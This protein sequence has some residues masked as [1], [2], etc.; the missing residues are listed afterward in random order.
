MDPGEQTTG[1]RDE[2]YN[3]VSVLYHALHGADNCD[4]YATDAEVS[5]RADLSDF[6]R[7]AQERQRGLADR[8]KGLL[9]IG[10]GT[11]TAGAG[12]TSTGA[13]PTG[14]APAGGD[15][16]GGA[17][18]AGRTS[19]A[20]G[21]PKGG[22][23]VGSDVPPTTDVLPE[24]D[25]PPRGADDLRA[26]TVPPPA[27]ISPETAPVGGIPSMT[28]DISPGA[29]RTESTAP[30]AASTAPIEDDVPR[31]ATLARD[32][33][34]QGETDL[35]TDVSTP[36]DAGPPD[37]EVASP[38]RAGVS[39]GPPRTEGALPTMADTTP[40][41]EGIPPGTDPIENDVPLDAPTTTEGTAT[42]AADATPVEDAPPRGADELRAETAPPTD[43][44]PT[45]VDVAS[46]ERADAPPEG[47]RTEEVSPERPRAEG[48]RSGT[49]EVSIRPGE[50]PS[51]SERGATSGENIRS[52]I[53]ESDRRS[54]GQI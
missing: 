39:T 40:T 31:D 1:T 50:E 47:P 28:E 4:I 54:R 42:T 46:P 9:G 10:G 6:F 52:I 24:E 27:D 41:E 21:I 5:G 43:T 18:V 11:A 32:V 34:P 38:E 16:A 19:A 3:L 7:E 30:I 14:T 49:E 15:L 45:E 22:G 12:T 35:P 48:A 13:T 33:P 51:K 23:V 17:T 53:R 8:A 26:E 29:R 44:A 37:V 2:H 36:P 25:V 20:G